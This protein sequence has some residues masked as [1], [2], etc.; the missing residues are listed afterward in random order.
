MTDLEDSFVWKES[1]KGCKD[2]LLTVKL[3]PE[4]ET[5]ENCQPSPDSSNSPQQT[6]VDQISASTQVY[7]GDVK[8]VDGQGGP[9]YPSRSS[10]SRSSF[11]VE[12]VLH[13]ERVFERQKY[14][15]SRDRQR[16]AVQ[17]QM[18]ETQVKTWFQNRRMKQKRKRAEDAER[19]VKLSFLSSL[20]HT[21]HNGHH[22]YQP[23]YESSRHPTY[24]D[25]PLVLRSELPSKYACPPASPWSSLRMPYYPP[26]P[27]PYWG[28]YQG[29]Y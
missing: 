28:R 12:Q 7:H 10:R 14:L 11:S 4:C 23:D 20:A 26:L 19:R 5:K 18:T 27:P 3:T 9:G 29:P 22:G 8:D 24:T 15:G 21:I 13:L 16:L 17:L 1:H 2:E 6:A 25:T